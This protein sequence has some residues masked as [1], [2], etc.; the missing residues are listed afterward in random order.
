MLTLLSSATS[1]FAR[2]VRIVLAEKKVEFQL[3]EASP[4]VPD[5]P[6]AAVNPLSK[7]PVLTLDDGTHLF[8]SRVIVDYVDSVSPVARL[9]PEATRQRVAV[10]RWEASVDGIRDALV[11]AVLEGR[12][13]VTQAQRRLDQ[14][15][16]REDRRRRRRDGARTG[17]RFLG[18]TVRWHAADIADR[19]ALGYID[20]VMA[21]AWIGA[22]GILNLA[23]LPTYSS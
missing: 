9:I 15:P 12:R 8:D 7:V 14:A 16:A 4:W 3:V 22:I 21:V 5:T 6:V 11:L 18:A 10:R 20:L 19:C 17:G 2:K 13:K 1:P 23:K